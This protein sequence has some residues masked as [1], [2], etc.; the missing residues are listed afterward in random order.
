MNTD[1]CKFLIQNMIIYFESDRYCVFICREFLD[2]FMQNAQTAWCDD[3][4]VK[5]KL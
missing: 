3:T 5:W 1:A 4:I 2:N